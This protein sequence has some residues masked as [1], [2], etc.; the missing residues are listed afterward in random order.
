MPRNKTTQVLERPTK[1]IN[2]ERELKNYTRENTYHP[3]QPNTKS[4][5][6]DLRAIS[7]IV[8]APLQHTPI[9]EYHPH[10]FHR[11]NI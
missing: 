3:N 1:Q 10:T 6:W 8:E 7:I 4:K 9:L 11:I 2:Q 5:A